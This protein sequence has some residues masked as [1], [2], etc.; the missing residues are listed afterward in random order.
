MTVEEQ[1]VEATK[2]ELEELLREGH[3]KEKRFQAA[4]ELFETVFNLTE[5]EYKI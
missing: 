3:E 2:L 1:E 5:E 4:E